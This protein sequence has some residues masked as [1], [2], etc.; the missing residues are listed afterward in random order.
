MK[1]LKK[2]TQVLLISTV[3]SYVFAQDADEEAPAFSVTGSVDTYLRY[4]LSNDFDTQPGTS[5][6][7][8]PGFSLGMANIILGYEGEKSGFVA[9]LVYGPRGEEAVFNS[10]GSSNIVNQMYVYFNE[11][12]FYCNTINYF[13]CIAFYKN[14]RGKIISI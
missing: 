4:N 2:I 5:F 11:P 1:N 9:D 3:F 8:L 6:A 7:N 14:I 12:Y 10:K 13:H